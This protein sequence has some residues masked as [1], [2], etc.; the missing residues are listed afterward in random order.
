MI[1]TPSIAPTTCHRL[2]V[3]NARQVAT[4]RSAT[5]DLRV[6]H[7]LLAQAPLVGRRSEVARCRRPA[8]AARSA[9]EDRIEGGLFSVPCCGLGEGDPRCATVLA[10]AESS[11][12]S[13]AALVT[14]PAGV[15]AHASCWQNRARLTKQPIGV[16][17]TAMA[18]VARQIPK[19][20]QAK[21]EDSAASETKWH[22]PT[23]WHRTQHTES[24]MATAN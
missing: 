22:Y 3:G 8:A 9:V 7:A 4:P 15:G 24:Q 14:F 20:Q 10:F 18:S 12:L 1:S 23:P 21:M 13:V 16:S 11:P 5:V 2:R 19:S 17:S 6:K